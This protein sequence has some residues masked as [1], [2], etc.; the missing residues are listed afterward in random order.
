MVENYYS[1]QAHKCTEV[2]KIKYLD[3]SE[4]DNRKIPIENAMNRGVF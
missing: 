1:E 2:I 4:I 3:Q